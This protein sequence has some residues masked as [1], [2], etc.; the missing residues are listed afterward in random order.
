M[1]N[2]VTKALQHYGEDAQG[3][4]YPWCA[5]FANRI[6][7]ESGIKGTDSLL[8]RSFLDIGIHTEIPEVGD[9]VVLWRVEKDS[10]YGHV[11]FYIADNHESIYILGGNQD[12]HV[13]I[14]A[15]PKWQLL[16]IRRISE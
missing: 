3:R 11:G 9:I 16:D 12:E 2:F 7:S 6:L 5:D 4:R 13:N 14:K 15:Y 1:L 8:A 10:I